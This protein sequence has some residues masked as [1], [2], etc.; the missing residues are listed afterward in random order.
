[1]LTVQTGLEKIVVDE[2]KFYISIVFK[3]KYS[4]EENMKI[5]YS[6]EFIQ[7]MVLGY[8]TTC[9]YQFIFD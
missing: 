4:K 7:N 5:Q 6:N 1:M 8:P 3:E 2:V 9:V